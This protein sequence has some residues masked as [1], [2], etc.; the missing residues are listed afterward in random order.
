VPG[1]VIVPRGF[2]RVS[3]QTLVRWQE[4]IASVE[5]RLIEPAGAVR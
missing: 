3:V 5:V 1:Q 4:A 2:D